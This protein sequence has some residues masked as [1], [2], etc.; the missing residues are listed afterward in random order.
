M[1]DE[2]FRYIEDYML[3]CMK[4]SAHDRDHIYRVLYVALD[5]ASYEEHVDYDVLIAACLLHDIGR[6]EQFLDPA[7]DHALAGGEKAYDFLRFNGWEEAPAQHVKACIETHRYRTD[8]LPQSLEAKIVYDADKIDATGTLG[9]ARTISYRADRAEPLYTLAPDGTVSDGSADSAPSF[10]QEY[11]FKLE[12]LYGKFY[13]KRA[14]AL[15]VP[16][17][18]SAAD[19]Y[20]SMLAEIKSSY[21]PGRSLLREVLEAGP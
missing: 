14:A 9:I 17:Q 21:D 2:Q 1:T 10:L 12:K 11:K 15:M 6:E 16:R 5:I 3:L 4:D 8:R 13:T 7:V 20:R 19:F 18:K